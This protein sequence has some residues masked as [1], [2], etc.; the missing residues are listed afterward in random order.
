M[1]ADFPSW[2]SDL[3]GQGRTNGLADRRGECI[4]SACSHYH[5]CFIEKSIRNSRRAEIVIANHALVLIQSVLGEETDIHQPTRYIFDEGHHLFEAADTVFSTYL[6]GAEAFD[7][8]RWLLGAE[9]R[10][11]GRSR[12]LKLSL[13]HI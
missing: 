9:T 4:Y 13:I 12:G 2:L 8:R 11:L 3:L 6:S 10:N 7:L 1:G 5:K